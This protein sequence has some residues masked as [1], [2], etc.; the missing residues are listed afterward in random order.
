MMSGLFLY[1][2]PKGNRLVLSHQG[3]S[4]VCML[5]CEVRNKRKRGIGGK[6]ALKEPLLRDL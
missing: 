5:R 2:V 6:A 1:M 4:I 3:S